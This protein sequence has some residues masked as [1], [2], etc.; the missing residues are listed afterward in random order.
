MNRAQRKPSRTPYLI[1]LD[2]VTGMV[3]DLMAIPGNLRTHTVEDMTGRLINM[4]A[5]QQLA[6]VF[7]VD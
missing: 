2:E 5:G 6:R 3:C 4:V 1:G 7:G